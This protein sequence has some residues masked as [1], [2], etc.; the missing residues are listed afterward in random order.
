MEVTSVIG[1]NLGW[2]LMKYWQMQP[3]MSA[4]LN[5]EQQND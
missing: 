1:H 4:T 5:A 2:R 3:Q